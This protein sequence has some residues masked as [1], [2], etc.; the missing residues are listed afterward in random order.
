MNNSRNE[1][2]QTALP[3]NKDSFLFYSNRTTQRIYELFKTGEKLTVV[4]LTKTLHIS[5]PRS[6]IRYIRNAGVNISDYWVYD[7][8]SR[9]KVY[10]LKGGE[11]CRQ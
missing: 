11:S 3:Q 8:N 9:H 1:I 4:G 7:E 5:D 6:H 10:F 2:A